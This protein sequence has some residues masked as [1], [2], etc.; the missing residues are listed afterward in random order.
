MNKAELIAA[1]EDYDDD[2]TILIASDEE[3]NRLS[4][5]SEA[6]ESSVV[7]DVFEWHAIDD[8]DLIDYE[9]EQVTSALILWG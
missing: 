2:T 7:T 8:S 6:T 9:D 3:W 1:L 5:I 4:P